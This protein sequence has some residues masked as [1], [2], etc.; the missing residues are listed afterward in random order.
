MGEDSIEGEHLGCGH[1]RPSAC[2]RHM[3]CQEGGVKES[4]LFLL[5]VHSDE[6]G[7][8][9][10]VAG[11]Y[12]PKHH[13]HLGGGEQCEEEETLEYLQNLS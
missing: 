9:V 11:W 12:H 3:T 1:T 4:D 13:F 2:C 8:I 5:G 10:R 6:G 7:C